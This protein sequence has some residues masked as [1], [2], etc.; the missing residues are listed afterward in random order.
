MLVE[1]RDVNFSYT[2]GPHRKNVL[3]GVNLSIDQGELIGLIGPT[4]AGKSTLILLASGL[5]F[6]TQ[7]TILFEGRRIDNF[8]EVRGKIGVLFQFPESQ[9]F[10]P[11]VFDEIAFGLKNFGFSSLEIR[12]RVF[13]ILTQ[14]GINFEDF[15]N[16]SPFSLSDGEK[17]RVALAS[18]LAFEPKIIFLDEPTSNL[19]KE[20][21]EEIFS[22]LKLLNKKKNIAIVIASHDVDEIVEVVERVIVLNKGQILL[23]DSTKK[24]FRSYDELKKMG[25]EVPQIAQL[26]YELRK[27]GLRFSQD[28]LTVDEAKAAIMKGFS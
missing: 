26:F 20:G 12:E 27:R 15:K 6:P 5:L 13:N 25:L 22:Y 24:I 4:G 19:D 16:R 3:R 18:I 17:R 14:L 9:F 28:I 7:G 21:R 23:D 8:W 2:Q 11:T 1:L 10:E